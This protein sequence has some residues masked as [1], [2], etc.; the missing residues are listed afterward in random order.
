MLQ[1][2]KYIFGIAYNILSD[3]LSKQDGW[4]EE[5]GENVRFFTM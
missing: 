1:K 3:S 4:K 2:Y 5:G